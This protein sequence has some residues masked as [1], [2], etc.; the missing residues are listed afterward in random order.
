MGKKQLS[1]H[2]CACQCSD[3]EDCWWK[4][5]WSEESCSCQI[6]IDRSDMLYATITMLCLIVCMLILTTCS[7]R[8]QA[9]QLQKTLDSNTTYGLS[10]NL[11]KELVRIKPP[12]PN[13][14][15]MKAV[16]PNNGN[17]A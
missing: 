16:G 12:K 11:L 17:A 14:S 2:L 15:R 6:L 3:R 5:E 8:R 7:S 9:R 10:L 4:Q 13:K 1:P